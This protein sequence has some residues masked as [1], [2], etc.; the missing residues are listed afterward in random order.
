LGYNVKM[1]KQ[2]PPYHTQTID[3]IRSQ[4]RVEDNGLNGAEVEKRRALYGLNTLPE[5]KADSLFVIFLRQ[6]QSPLIFI[7]LFATA[8]VFVVGEYIDGIVIS[9]VLLFNAIVGTVQEG[10]AQNIF[11]AL[12]N[13]VA[14]DASVLRDG[15]EFIIAE[16]NVVMG[17]IIILREGQKVP[18]DARV[19]A[20]ESLQVDE[21]AITGESHPSYKTT[22]VISDPNILAAEKT[23]MV[24]KGTAVVSG[25]G[26]A[27]VV[28]TGTQTF[29]GRIAERIAHIDEDLPIKKDIQYL[30]RIIIILVVAIGFILIELGIYYGQPMH[31]ILMMVVAVSVSVI[32]EGLPIV[33]TLVLA[34]GVWRMGKRN[35][36]IKRLQAVEALGQ[37]DVIAVDK[38]GTI[39]KNELT[40]TEV[41]AGERIFTINGVGYEAKGSVEH[42]GENIDATNHPELL[43][44]GKIGMLCSGAHVAWDKATQVWRVSGDPLEAATLV[45]AEKIGF[46]RA[47]VENE[48][49]KIDEMPFDYKLKYHA[50]LYKE[51]DQYSV[52]AVGAPETILDMSDALWLPSGTV[53]LTADMRTQ[54]TETF[55]AMSARGLRVV[56]CGIKHVAHTTDI[57]DAVSA[58]DFVG[59]FGIEDAARPEVMDAVETVRSVGIKLVMITGDHK[60]TAQTIAGTIGIY[61][62]GDDIMEGTEVDRMSE[63]ELAKQI[64]TVSVFA[65][66]TPMH[67]L[68]IINAYKLAGKTVA[69]TGDGVNDALSLTAASVGVAMGKVGTEVAKEASD[70]VLLD[71]NFGSIVSGVEEGRNIFITIKRVIL[72]L[73]STGL[74]EVVIIITAIAMGMPLPLLAVHILWLNLVTDG[75]LD[76][77]LAM[78]PKRKG[79]SMRSPGKK[80]SGLIDRVMVI[81]MVLMAG[82]MAVGTL[83]LFNYYYPID[84]AK[85]WTVS[86]TTMAVFQWFN[87]WNCRSRTASIFFSHPFSNKYLILATIVVIA[88]QLF[89]IYHPFMHTYFSTVPLGVY[90]WL[91]IIGI[92]LSIIV[93]EELRKIVLFVIRRKKQQ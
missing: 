5:A 65:R 44:V 17:D 1:E 35:V 54:L 38:T 30:S 71:D 41:Y 26:R 91:P 61:R 84:L 36:L 53:P 43:M 19:I 21:S 42:A 11:A 66:V 7:L 86:L 56:A 46:S 75:F 63:D 55:L 2:I 85:A 68:K 60:L 12:K 28:G 33:V 27:I 80:R 16:E 47:N 3:E 6:F 67:K 70:I 40:V 64:D 34:T 24:F 51:S 29:I 45:L 37:T 76:V 82:T 59:F 13:F 57:H 14:S 79:M 92:A 23:N 31:E 22:D 72:Y 78:E 83:Y 90:D 25:N 81:R 74:G 9:V 48:M 62:D 93:V 49:T 8:A 87:A 58:I 89:A 15:E 73:L 32:P 69:M 18:A 52:A 4:L 10:R 77:A 88:L 50:V 20:A 39:T